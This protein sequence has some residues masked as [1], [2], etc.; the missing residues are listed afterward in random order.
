MPICTFAKSSGYVLI[1]ASSSIFNPQL[2][3]HF[4]LFKTCP[5]DT[6]RLGSPLSPS[7]QAFP[8]PSNIRRLGAP[9]S[10]GL[11]TQSFSCHLLSHCALLDC[12]NFEDFIRVDDTNISISSLDLSEFQ[13][14]ILTTLV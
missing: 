11:T 2:V 9:P 14:T 4:F 6:M 8:L 3:H 13:A 10:S 12:H 7:L 1:L 5:S